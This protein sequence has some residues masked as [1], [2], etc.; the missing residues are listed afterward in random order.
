MQSTLQRVSHYYRQQGISPAAF[1]EFRCPHKD[2]CK[3]HAGTAPGR[4][5]VCGRGAWISQGYE[6][7]KLPRVLVLSSDWGGDEGS[8]P[9]ERRAQAVRPGGT[10]RLQQY[11]EEQEIVTQ[12]LRPFYK[13]I[14]QSDLKVE[15]IYKFYARTNSIKCC[16]NRAASRQAPQRLFQNCLEYLEPEIELL[17]PDILVSQ[18]DQAEKVVKSHFRPKLIRKISTDGKWYRALIGVGRREVLWVRVPFPRSFS[19]HPKAEELD[20]RYSQCAKQVVRFFD[21]RS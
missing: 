1:V 18:G 16:A 15:D 5:F 9:S 8:Q 3:A 7:H 11:R 6:Q 4:Q 20:I 21:S 2:D 14:C 13:R 10:D 12:L 19:Y 17:A